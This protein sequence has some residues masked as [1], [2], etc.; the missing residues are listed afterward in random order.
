MP[1]G[2]ASLLLTGFLASTLSLGGCTYVSA[3]AVVQDL[4]QGETQKDDQRTKAC[5]RVRANKRAATDPA[6]I[7]QWEVVIDEMNCP[8]EWEALGRN[9]DQ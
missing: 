2:P 8:T 3:F 6:E 5:E 1:R 9:E 7:R 4:T